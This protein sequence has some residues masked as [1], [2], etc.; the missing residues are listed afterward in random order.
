MLR[1]YRSRILAGL[2]IVALG[3]WIAV[4][5]APGQ[6]PAYPPAG[7]GGSGF[8]NPSLARSQ[9]GQNWASTQGQLME[10]HDYAISSYYQNREV[11]DAY[12]AEQ[13]KLHPPLTQEQ[14]NHWAQE[15]SAGRLSTA[16]FDRS[17][18]VIH[19]PPLLRDKRFTDPRCQL[20]RLFHNRTPNN[21]GVDSDSYVQI[22]QTC[23]AM[24]AILDG[25]INQ[26]PPETSIAAGHFIRSLSYEGR[27]AAK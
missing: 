22:K 23:D 24:Q 7:Y 8:T 13:L 3:V 5:L 27:F 20:D 16:Q 18:N 17:T 26:L 2:A 21:S 25:M 4:N 9:A 14:A 19:W 11:H 12:Q 15:L 1:S 6:V 10:N